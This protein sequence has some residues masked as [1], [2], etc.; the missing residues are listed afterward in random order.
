MM[1]AGC[2]NM[3][4][5]SDYAMAPANAPV[6]DDPSFRLSQLKSGM[7]KLQL[8]AIYG[9]RLVRKDRDATYDLYLVASVAARPGLGLRREFW[10]TG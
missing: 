6:H 10:R 5:L 1:L 7:V 3:P 8:D 2:A 9:K 4:G